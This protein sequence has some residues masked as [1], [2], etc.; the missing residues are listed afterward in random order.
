[1]GLTTDEDIAKFEEFK[2]VQTALLKRILMK[3][4]GPSYRAG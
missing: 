1:M 2:A 3:K 4:A